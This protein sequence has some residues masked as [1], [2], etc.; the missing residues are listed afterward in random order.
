MKQ[1]NYALVFV[2]RLHFFPAVAF[3]SS[4]WN[5]MVEKEELKLLTQKG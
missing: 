5:E 4:F 2:L 1:I 3:T